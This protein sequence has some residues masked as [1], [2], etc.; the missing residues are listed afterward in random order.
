MICQSFVIPKAE[1]DEKL[2]V[3]CTKKL[4]SLDQSGLVILAGEVLS[5][6]TYINLFDANTWGKYTGIEDWRLRIKLKGEGTI[7]L[8]GLDQTGEVEIA[9]KMIDSKDCYESI[10]IP[11]ESRSE[12]HFFY[13]KI[14]AHK[15]IFLKEA[16]YRPK[17]ISNAIRK[18]S[19]AVNIC[20]YKRKEQLEKNLHLFRSMSF[21]DEKSEWYQGLRVFVTDNASEIE[22]RDEADLKVIHNK[23]TGGSGGF[24]RGIK[25]I[26]SAKDH[27]DN[28]FSHV[29]FMDDDVDFIDESFYRLYA[30]LSLMKDEYRDTVVAGRMFRTDNKKVQYTAA[31]IWNRGQIKHIGWNQDMTVQENLRFI[32]NNNNAE[33]SGWWFACFPM[34]FVDE[35]EPLPFFIHCD[36]VEYGLRIKE[37]PILLNGIQVWHETYEYRNSP[38][39][40]YYDMRNSLLVNEI[41]GNSQ[42][43]KEVLNEWM[44]KI[45]AA[46][47]RKEWLTEYMMIKGF[48]DYLRGVRFLYQIDSER[49]H[50]R[51]LRIKSNRYKNA[52]A[53]RIVKNISARYKK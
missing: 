35:N 17:E 33:Y 21:Y 27:Q 15:E 38:I 7:S 13:F 44:E 50:K 29:I 52:V 31:E 41:T 42:S 43:Q 45:T 8:C 36:D 5:T 40:A 2:F 37:N 12:I 9:Q 48:R 23:N 32:N 30:L 24:G 39:M 19:L 18:I 4:V 6:D 11:F 47:L 16:A 20:T 28:R 53:W 10:E 51:L 1:Y 22:E 25:E 49:Y 14:Q 3:R 34:K 26:R 46:H